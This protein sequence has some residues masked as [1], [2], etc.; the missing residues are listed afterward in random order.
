M[1]VSKQICSICVWMRIPACLQ[2]PPSIKAGPRRMANNLTTA[3]AMPVDAVTLGVSIEA[4]ASAKETESAFLDFID[5]T[6]DDSAAQLLPREI[7]EK[8]ITYA[9][10]LHFTEHQSEWMEAWYCFCGTCSLSEHLSH[11][12]YELYKKEYMHDEKIEEDIED[13]EDF[14]NW[15][16]SCRI[17]IYTRE[18]LSNIS[19][20]EQKFSEGPDPWDSDVKFKKARK[21]GHSHT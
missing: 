19:F 3:W 6:S 12:T 10:Q 11:K 8:I 17:G 7:I 2:L 15:L 18:H 1:S 13:D 5:D 16:K 9:Q 21:V 20:L 4:Y 14:D